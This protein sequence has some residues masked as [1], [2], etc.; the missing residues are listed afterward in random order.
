MKKYAFNLFVRHFSEQAQLIQLIRLLYIW[1]S[2][3]RANNGISHNCYG[4]CYWPLWI[5]LSMA[6]GLKINRKNKITV[7]TYQ[8]KY[9]LFWNYFF[10]SWLEHGSYDYGNKQ[11]KLHF[12]YSTI[13][14]KIEK[15]SP[16]GQE[17][18]HYTTSFNEKKKSIPNTI[19]FLL[20]WFNFKRDARK[21]VSNTL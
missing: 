20:F 14:R 6:I 15:K 11:M 7:D 2:S 18:L 17:M 4:C 21:S 1:L 9:T 3:E 8:R 13:W 16:N 5:H 12:V 10:F 19:F